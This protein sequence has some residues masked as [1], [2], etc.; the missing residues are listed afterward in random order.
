MNAL[1]RS[2]S[3]NASEDLRELIKEGAD[4][5]LKAIHKVEQEAQLNET[6][7]KFSLG[8]KI[9][10]DFDKASYDCDLSWSLK[11][12]LSTSHKIEDPNQGNLDGVLSGN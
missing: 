6:K 3:E 10:V 7:P 8:F 5:I 9:T 2:I 4:D 11:Q 12:T 1:L